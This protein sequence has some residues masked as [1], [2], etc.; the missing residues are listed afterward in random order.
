MG[1]R[2]NFVI[3]KGRTFARS[4]YLLDT[5]GITENDLDYLV[6]TDSIP[7]V[8]YN[9]ETLFCLEVITLWVEAIQIAIA[10][11]SVSE[12]RADRKTSTPITDAFFIIA[13]N[14]NKEKTIKKSRKNKEK[15]LHMY[16][17][18]RWE[19]FLYLRTGQ[20]I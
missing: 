13:R 11:D 9:G 17:T 12:Y 15:T 5:L 7:H 3:I 4:Q 20:K 6:K 8:S 19:Y 1:K 10:A 18:K 14:I 2:N 16:L